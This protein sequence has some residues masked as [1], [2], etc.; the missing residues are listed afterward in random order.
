MWTTVARLRVPLGFACAAAALM[1]AAPS[2]RSWTIGLGVAL[3][4]EL[5]RLWAAGHIEKGREITQSGPYHYVRH[6]LYLGSTLIG[7]GFAAASLSWA[8]MVLTAGY[9]TITLVAAVRTEETALNRKFE[10]A[11]DAYRSGRRDTAQRAFSWTRVRRNR[12]YKAVLGLAAAF[13]YLAFR[14]S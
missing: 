2:W 6:P 5:V 13:L 14:A 1:L 11:Y 10:G 7:I 8:V 12:E 9:L 3:A 4:G